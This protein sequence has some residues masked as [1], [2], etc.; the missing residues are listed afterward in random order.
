MIFENKINT[1]IADKFNLQYTEKGTGQ[2][3]ILL[4]GLFG[5][6]SNWTHTIRHFSK[7]YRVIVP[8]LP[9]YNASWRKDVLSELVDY[10]HTLV[11]KL[12]LKD[13]VLVGNSLGGHVAILYTLAHQEYVSNLVL[14]GS[15][16]LFESNLGV[17]YPKRGNFEYISEKVKYTF[18]NQEVASTTLINEVY[19]TVNDVRKSI[20]IIKAAKAANRHHVGK[21][22]AKIK[23]PTLLIW[24]EQDKVTPL[25][26]AFQ[27]LE[28][29]S[30]KSELHVI[31]HCGHAPMMEQPQQFNQ[32][33]EKYLAKQIVSS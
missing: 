6:L 20:G 16:G 9:I 32:I 26:V 31:D 4:H 18:Y 3:I 27:F 7:N 17:S 33:L 13:V 8:V 21:E 25:E 5:S 2:P 19:Q 14:T 29:L 23:V 12:E 1:I 28:L 11:L 30:A 15:S 22:L 10:V 24:G